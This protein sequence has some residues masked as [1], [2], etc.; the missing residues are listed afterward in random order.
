[1]T[2]N[3][4]TIEGRVGNAPV[5][6]HFQSGSG[7]AEFSVAITSKRKDKATGEYQDH[8]VWMPVK[9]LGSTQRMS[10]IE[11]SCGKGAKV[12]L[13]GCIDQDSW[14]KDGQKVTKL[15]ML[16]N[17]ISVMSG[18]GAPSA[19]SNAAPAAPAPSDFSDDDFAF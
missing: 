6:K 16:A 1:M 5:V 2:I 10:F 12:V 7:V 9:I 3:T 13:S 4:V 19:A 11:T 18:T 15:Y 8:T 14:V 17:D